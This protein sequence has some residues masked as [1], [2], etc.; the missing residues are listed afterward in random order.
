MSDQAQARM[1]MIKDMHEGK[2]YLKDHNDHLDVYRAER[3]GL[4]VICISNFPKDYCNPDEYA[5]RY[6]ERQARV[7]SKSP[8]RHYAN[9]SLEEPTWMDRGE[10]RKVVMGSLG[11]LNQLRWKQKRADIPEISRYS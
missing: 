4:K 11:M 7:A 10:T 8:M 1:G 5:P 3:S 2:V 9:A 6:H